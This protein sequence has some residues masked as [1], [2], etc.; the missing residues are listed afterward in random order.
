[1]I[2]LGAGFFATA[3][4]GYEIHDPAIGRFASIETAD[5]LRAI[6]RDR[7]RRW[8]RAP[9]GAVEQWRPEDQYLSEGLWHVERR[10]DAY[11]DGDLAT[12]WGE[13]RILETYYA[14]VLETPPGVPGPGHRWPA[15]QRK[16]VAVQPGDPAVFV[17]DAH[18][19]P[20]Y[21]W[22][23]ERFWAIIA[24]ICLLTLLMSLIAARRVGSPQR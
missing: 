1:V 10:N 15:A 8:R 6:G 11:A 13:N 16:T 20:I 17:S 3:H 12:A 19:Y 14:P 7:E 24:S 4:L 2:L 9:R 22:P 23:R 5:R 18:P 21:T